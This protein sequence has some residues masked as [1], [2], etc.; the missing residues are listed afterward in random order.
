MAKASERSLERLRAIHNAPLTILLTL[1]AVFILAPGSAFGGALAPTKASQL[2]TLSGSGSTCLSGLKK[3]DT[4][5]HGDGTTAAFTI[6]AGMVLIIT[7]AEWDATAGG[8]AVDTFFI[9]LEGTGT[10]TVHVAA[11]PVG[12]GAGLAGGSTTFSSGIVVKPS[13]NICVGLNSLNTPFAVIHGFL[14]KDK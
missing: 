13:T 6:P 1:L 2:V 3:M 10:A 14:A 11:G 5:A 8:N 9:N 7:G 12:S 4:Q